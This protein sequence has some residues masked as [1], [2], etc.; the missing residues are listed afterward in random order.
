MRESSVLFSLHELRAIEQQRVADEH[1]AIVREREAQAAAKAA[2]ERAARE[3][4]EARIAAERDEAM[5]IERARADAERE[6]RL[7]IESKEAAERA[8]LAA[9]LEHERMQQELELRRQEI[10]QKRPRWM[11]A[12]TG[13]AVAA[14][15]AL[16][17]FGIDRMRDAAAARGAEEMAI[18]AKEKSKQD[19]AEAQKKLGEMRAELHALEGKVDSATQALEVAQNEADREKARI[20]LAEARKEKIE[21][22]RKLDAWNAEQAHLKRIQKVDVSKCAGQ[23]LGC[24]P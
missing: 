16:T 24:I 5:R 6:L 11:L 8:R 7:Q 18:A 21:A 13:C 4:E 23:S 12:V 19:A 20:A 2:A 15:I 17:W 10:L 14:A 3:A 1:A 22:Q 9:A